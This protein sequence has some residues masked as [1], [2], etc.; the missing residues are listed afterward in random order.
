[1]AKST[2]TA[3]AYTQTVSSEDVQHA[4]FNEATITLR[5]SIAEQGL[6]PASERITSIINNPFNKLLKVRPVSNKFI[7]YC[8]IT[9]SLAPGN[10][11]M[12]LAMERD[13]LYPIVKNYIKERYNESE[14]YVF[15]TKYKSKDLD[16]TPYYWNIEN[17]GVDLYVTE[18][19]PESVIKYLLLKYS[20]LVAFIE[21]EVDADML[22]QNVR[23]KVVDEKAVVTKQLYREETK[24][25]LKYRIKNFTDSEIKRLGIVM[26]M[27]V[28]ELEPDQLRQFFYTQVD[29]NMLQIE[30]LLNDP[31]LDNKILLAELFFYN[32]FIRIDGEI[33][34]SNSERRFVNEEELIKFIRNPNNA[35]YVDNWKKELEA[36]KL[37]NF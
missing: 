13:P 14:P 17:N 3:P 25:E 29:T 8:T 27:N 2:F 20:P 19:D 11:G 24:I 15:F 1:M 37:S 32:V 6:R 9:A 36:N 33:K 22:S 16:K 7:G 21:D 26:E 30:K 31:N 12:Y 23:F 35:T 10:N 4:P 28:L 34:H 5:D 18:S